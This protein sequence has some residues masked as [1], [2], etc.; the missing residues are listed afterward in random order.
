MCL[1]ENL[2]VQT[3]GDLRITCSFRIRQL[4]F[5]NLVCSDKDIITTA[6]SHLTGQDY[7]ASAYNPGLVRMRM[8]GD[9]T[10]RSK[11]RNSAFFLNH[12]GQNQAELVFSATEVLGVARDKFVVRHGRRQRSALRPSDRGCPQT[13]DRHLA[14]PSL[15]AAAQQK[16]GQATHCHTR[17][18]PIQSGN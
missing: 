1:S 3:L 12:R 6:Y 10:L 15:Q 11:L 8:R 13:K 9:R 7:R 17:I 4:N 14:W 16:L 2:Q 5:L 18:I